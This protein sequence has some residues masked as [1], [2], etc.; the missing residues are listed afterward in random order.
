[1]FPIFILKFFLRIRHVTEDVNIFGGKISMLIF[2]ALFNNYS[3]LFT[4][5]GKD[6]VNYF[7]LSVTHGVEATGRPFAFALLH[8]QCSVCVKPKFA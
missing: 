8:F 1:M 6:K 3:K 4:T 2:N 5:V 7:E